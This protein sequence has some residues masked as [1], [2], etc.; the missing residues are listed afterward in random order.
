MKA[1]REAGLDIT[2]AAVPLHF[3]PTIAS[4]MRTATAIVG[5]MESTP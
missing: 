2:H 4:C 1:S 5:N 3:S